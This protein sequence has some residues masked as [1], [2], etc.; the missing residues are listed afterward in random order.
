MPR[1]M[2]RSRSLRRRKLRTPGARLVTHYKRK[3]GGWYRCALCKRPLFGVPKNVREYPK[4]SRRPERPYGGFLCA[5]CLRK[6]ITKVAIEK[7]ASN[8]L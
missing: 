2:H 1:P 4:T 5:E 7:S 8:I 6:L 3:E